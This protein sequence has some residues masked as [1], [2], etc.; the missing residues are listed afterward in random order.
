MLTLSVLMENAAASD[1]FVCAHGLSFFL[2]SDDATIL[3]DTGPND[4]FLGNA[5]RM[6]CDIAK[7]THIVLS[8][9]HYDH[10][11]GL[12][13]ALGHIRRA[14]EGRN[15]PPLV[16]HPGITAERRRPLNSPLGAKDLGIPADGRKELATWPLTLAKEPLYI[17]DR[18]VF[19]GEVPHT[20]PEMCALVGEAE[21]NGAYVK[22]MLPDDTALAY[23]TDAGLIIVAGCS[24]SGIVNII[25]HAKKV[26]GVEKIRAVYGGLHCKDMTADAIAGTKKALSEENLEEI[27]ACHCTGSALDDFPGQLRL[28]AGEKHTLR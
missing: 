6:G 5:E 20:R 1:A 3:F 16:A 10:T 7:T 26:T 27:Y 8:H 24:H 2:E 28:A 25:T 12:G 17:T 22:D 9:G 18:I 21:Q 11:G 15:L 23:I 4:A 19:L 13:A 14:K